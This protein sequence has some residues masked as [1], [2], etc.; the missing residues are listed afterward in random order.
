MSAFG[1][2]RDKIKRIWHP[3]RP[4]CET[5]IKVALLISDIGDDSVAS[6][7]DGHSRGGFVGV[8]AVASPQLPDIT[9]EKNRVETDHNRSQP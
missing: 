8:G 4:F 5:A 1:K 3:E 9:V 6:T 7:L 2:L